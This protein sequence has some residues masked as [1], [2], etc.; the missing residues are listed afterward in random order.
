MELTCDRTH[1]IVFPVERSADRVAREWLP[2]EFVEGVAAVVAWRELGVLG[3][4]VG[5]DAAMVAVLKAPAAR[6]GLV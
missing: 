3:E 1:G 4:V 5:V 6:F 2:V